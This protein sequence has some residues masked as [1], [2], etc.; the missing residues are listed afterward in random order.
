MNKVESLMKNSNDNNNNPKQNIFQNSNINIFNYINK[1]LLVNHFNNFYQNPFEDEDVTNNRIKNRYLNPY[2][3]QKILDHIDEYLFKHYKNLLD[4]NSKNSSISEKLTPN[5]KFFVIK[6]F[7]EEDIHKSMKYGVWSSSKTGN[8][9]LDNNYKYCQQKNSNVFLFFSCN[10]SGRFCGVCKMITPVD[11]NKIFELWTQDNTWP[12]LFKVEWIFIK[13]VP[14]KI[15]NNIY[16]Q[17]NDKQYRPVSHSRDAQE[18]PYGKAKYMMD[19][20]AKYQNSNT[21]FERFEFY[22]IRQDYYVKNKRI[23]EQKDKEIKEKIMNEKNDNVENNNNNVE[24]NNSIS[25]NNI[26]NNA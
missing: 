8:K 4:I 1:N 2:I 13:D 6:S 18:I 25:N 22:D 14:L 12:G 15:F 5:D 10:K 17:M 24:N 20:F 23:K 26:N 11:F 7:T 16:I 21:I 19:R 9:V 3:D